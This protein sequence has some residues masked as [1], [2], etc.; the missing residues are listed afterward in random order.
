MINDLITVLYMLILLAIVFVTNTVLG[1]VIANKKSKFNFKKLLSGIGKGIIIALCMFLFCVTLELIPDVLGQVGITIQDELITV[2]E[3]VL[4]TFT[5]YKKYALDC[6]E[7]FK[8]ILDIK[9]SE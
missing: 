2:V 1:V 3:V 5:A 7:K 4:M 8:T 6:V 9:E